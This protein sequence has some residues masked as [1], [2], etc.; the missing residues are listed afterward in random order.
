MTAPTEGEVKEFPFL[1][2]LVNQNQTSFSG[3][4]P[5]KKKEELINFLGKTNMLNK[6]DM[7]FSNI[8]TTTIELSQCQGPLWCRVTLTAIECDDYSMSPLYR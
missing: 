6:H 1:L 2:R 7:L 4:A 8:I 5:F 3:L